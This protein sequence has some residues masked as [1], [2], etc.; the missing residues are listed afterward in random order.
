MLVLTLPGARGTGGGDQRGWVLGA[1]PHANLGISEHEQ[2]RA[3]TP[4][5]PSSRTPAPLDPCT[6]KARAGVRVQP[7]LTS[8]VTGS[9]LSLGLL[10]CTTQEPGP[11][12]RGTAKT[13]PRLMH[14]T[15]NQW[16]VPRV[17][18]CPAPRLNPG[19]LTRAQTSG[20]PST[21]GTLTLMTGGV[22]G[23]TGMMG[24]VGGGGAAAGGTGTD[25]TFA[26]IVGT[27]VAAMTGVWETVGGT[28]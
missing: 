19:A 27:G 5:P 2:G 7:V 3:E 18:S 15:P 14:Q 9:S 4:P 21:L 22:G 6:A 26:V 25:V 11:D 28:F 10:V 23:T 17:P 1:C 12:H 16:S 24:V 8:C 13:T 20:P